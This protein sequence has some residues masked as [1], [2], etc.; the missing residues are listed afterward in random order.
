MQCRLHPTARSRA[1]SP[2]R[3][4]VQVLH[5]LCDSQVELDSRFSGT[6]QGC[7][8]GFRRASP[9]NQPCFAVWLVGSFTRLPLNQDDV[10]QGRGR[11]NPTAFD[12]S[13]WTLDLAV[14]GRAQ[15]FWFTTQPTNSSSHSR[16]AH[17]RLQTLICSNC[18]Y[19]H[20]N[21]A[22]AVWGGSAIGIPFANCGLYR[23]S[24]NLLTAAYS[25][26]ALS[27]LT[28]QSRIFS[29]IIF[30]QQLRSARYRC[31]CT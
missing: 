23:F 28:G 10:N 22:T 3:R 11:M 9:S 16:L 1:S 25:V 18:R 7:L 26:T 2:I 4:T 14:S 5:R 29:Y 20:L 15:Q 30:C 13:T 21:S 27:G 12:D 17:N 8:V 6:C 24:F 19:G 31:R